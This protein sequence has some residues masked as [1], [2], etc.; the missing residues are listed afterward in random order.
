MREYTSD[1]SS[2]GEESDAE[3]GPEG[4]LEEEPWEDWEEQTE[5]EICRCLFSEDVCDSVERAL[6]IDASKNGFDLKKFRQQVGSKCMRFQND[7][8]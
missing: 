6:H 7:S 4:S 3:R 5:E 1:A 8:R 2:C